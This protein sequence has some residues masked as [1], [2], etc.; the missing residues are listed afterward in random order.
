MPDEV[1]LCRL[2]PAHHSSFICYSPTSALTWLSLSLY[3]SFSLP[4]KCFT[5]I[6]ARLISFLHKIFWCY[7][8]EGVFTDL[9]TSCF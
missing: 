1:Y 6:S 4:G 9:L 7:V 8:D 2:A 5:Q 3:L